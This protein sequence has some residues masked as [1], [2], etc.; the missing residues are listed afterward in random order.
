[1]LE[2]ID[3][4]ITCGLM[5]LTLQGC[6]SMIPASCELSDQARYVSTYFGDFLE[7]IL[8]FKAESAQ[9]VVIKRLAI[10]VEK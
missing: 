7:V 3:D 4:L 9:L 8:D 2:T 1:M 5:T 10:L 6:M